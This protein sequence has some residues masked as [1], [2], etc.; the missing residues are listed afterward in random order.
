MGGSTGGST[1]SGGNSGNGASGGSGG[2]DSG[3][4]A[5]GTGGTQAPVDPGVT[6][7]AELA[8]TDDG[9]NIVSY[10]GYLNGESFQQDGVVS[11]GT[12]QYAAF[13][14]SSR[15][16]VLGRRA[17]PNGNWETLEFSDYSNSEND[18]HNTISI[19][20]CPGDGTLHLSFDHH[21]NNLHYRKSVPNL[22]TDPS[23]VAFAT[24]SFGAVTSSLVGSTTLAQVTYP[25]FVTE[26]AATNSCSRRVS[27][28]A[29][30]VTSTFG[31]TT[32][33]RATGPRSACT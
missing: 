30:R 17:L 2:T 23:S 13:W 14:N 4:G 18:A 7:D 1:A 19:G 11:Y 22:V 28:R 8:L 26:P 32:Q 9:L 6:K 33:R 24:G 15:H 31:S 12:Y 5:T 27:A 3:G 10:G 21:G 29:A 20:I 25:R 16:V